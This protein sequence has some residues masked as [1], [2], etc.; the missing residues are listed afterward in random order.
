MVFREDP[1]R[2]YL[3]QLLHIIDFKQGVILFDQLVRPE[4]LK[5]EVAKQGTVISVLVFISIKERSRNPLNLKLIVLLLLTFIFLQELL[6]DFGLLLFRALV[7][8]GLLI[9][10][11]VLIYR[12]SILVG[13][14]HFLV[15]CFP[16]WLFSLKWGVVHF[17]LGK[18]K[19][20]GFRLV[21]AFC[22]C[23]GTFLLTGCP[24]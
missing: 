17:V 9:T 1:S 12:L 15:C 23:F 5:P 24:L 10:T 2:V 4:W 20:A 14:L 16:G 6:Q 7:L 18:P 19:P 8:D 11:F 21:A 22:D 13:F 3:R